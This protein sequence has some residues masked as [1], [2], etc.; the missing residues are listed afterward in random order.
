MATTS[1]PPAAVHTVEAQLAD[2]DDESPF[3]KVSVEAVPE[4]VARAVEAAAAPKGER[5]TDAMV[6]IGTEPRDK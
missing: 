3:I 6:S 5:W 2:S 4:G 1:A